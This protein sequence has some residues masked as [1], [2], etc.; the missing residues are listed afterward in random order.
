MSGPTDF[1][2]SSLSNFEAGIAAL[3]LASQVYPG[4]TWGDLSNMLAGE[5]MAGWWTDL[6][7]VAGDIKDGV[8]D[9]LKSTGDFIGDK[10]GDIIRLG[11]DEKVIDGASRLGTA[12]VTGGGSE[13]ARGVL[14]SIGLSGTSSDNIMDFLSSLGGIFKEKTGTQSSVFGVDPKVL[15]WAI[16]GMAVLVL[17]FGKRA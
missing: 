14:E 8:G 3:T 12:Y 2:V 9:V 11:T 17:I 6:K 7:G 4:L 5:R 10:G 13:G 16:A 15:P 1:D